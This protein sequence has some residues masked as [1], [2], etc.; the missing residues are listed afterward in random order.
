V[1]A[2][3]SEAQASDVDLAVK[4]ARKA[5]DHGPWRSYSGS[6]RCRILLN[7][8]DLILQNIEEI[9]YLEVIDNGK[10][11]NWAYDDIN[12]SVKVLRYYA[13]YCDKIHG[14]TIPME[15]PYL[16]YVRKEPVGVCAQVI[17]W[18]FP[19][20]MFWWKVAPA[21]AAGCTIVMKPAELT[22]LTALFLGHL[23]NE[24]GVPAGVINILPG[25]G[26]TCG[27]PL[28]Q[29]PLVDKVAFTGSTSVGYHIMR[30]CH[31][32]NLKRVSLEL[33][34]KSANIV[35]KDADIDSA[36]TYSIRGAFCNSGQSCIA[37]GRI[38]VQ[39]EVYDEFIKKAVE[40][41]KKRVVGDPFK[42]DCDQGPQ[43][44]QKQMDNVLR[45]V[46][47]GK[48]EGATILLGGKR[49]GNKGFFIESTVIGDVI[50]GMT[51]AKEEIFGPVLV[52]L[53]FKTLDEA[54][55]R[56]NNS[57]YGLGAGVF[58]KNMEVA[59]KVTNALKAGTVYVNCYDI[60]AVT[61]PFGGFKDSGIGRELGEY[62][63]SGYL[64]L[65]TVIIKIAD[66]ALP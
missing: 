23:F 58:T 14:T 61:T 50:E 28:V 66:D 59:I 42:K 51:I 10:P 36:V 45:L 4:A 19:F 8:S 63:L 38:Y 57:K 2:K 48:E 40:E 11:Y 54:I 9:A 22:P 26:L 16:A 1:I 47:K 17:P 55:E 7:L 43:I 39:E 21:L 5:F 3:I 18:N 60:C 32:H 65:K 29:H 20:M 25:F 52:V 33:G 44:S 37:P 34:G 27:T 49:L 64:E 30:N 62:G 15:G 13:G 12:E 35:L 53:K 6:K 31:E 46:E 41:A 24:A 56:A